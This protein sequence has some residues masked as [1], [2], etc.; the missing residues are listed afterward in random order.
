MVEIDYTN[1]NNNHLALEAEKFMNKER[2]FN[3][4]TRKSSEPCSYKQQLNLATKPLEYYV[5]SF[6]N[7]SSTNNP[8]LAFCP[9][10]NAAQQNIANVFDRPIPSHLNKT[11]P[12]Y[13]FNYNTSPNLHLESN[14]NIFDT[15]TDLFLKTGL[16][17]KNKNNNA[18][19]SEQQ[20]SVYGDIY[21]TEIE[22]LYQNAGQLAM[23]KNNQPSPYEN[24]PGLE[25]YVSAQITNGI[26]VIN[27]EAGQNYFVDTYVLMQNL[28]QG[29]LES[30]LDAFRELKNNK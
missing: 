7:I 25:E 17:L 13:H 3:Q 28:T 10:G 15:D 24:I 16:E 12:T 8:Q 6:N 14:I 1:T 5:N 22:S 26:G 29:R 23:S 2:L 21:K 30:N 27:F 11:S 4:I 18:A 9:V 20:W 19:L